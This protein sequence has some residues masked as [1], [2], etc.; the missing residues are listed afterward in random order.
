VSELR[1][2]NRGDVV[3][4]SSERLN[5]EPFFISSRDFEPAY[6]ALHRS[7]ELRRRVEAGRERLSHCL[8]CPRNC[9]VNRLVDKTAACKTGRYARVA[10]Y[11]PHSG[12]EN[13]LRG[14]RGSGT[15]FFAWCN[16][17][18]VFCQN[19]DISQMSAGVECS[20]SEIASMMLE[21][22]DEGCHNINFV[23]PE[24]VVPQLL[25]A[26]WIAAEAGLRLPIV[27]NTSAYDSLDSLHLLD[28]V[29]D[30][31]M[32]DFKFWDSSLALRYLKAKD[33]PEVARR[34]I[35]EMHR[36]VG[37]LKCDERGLAKRGVLVRHLLMPG[38]IDDTKAIL[39]F[40]AEEVSIDT[41]V[42][43]MSQYHPAGKV[44]A[45]KYAELDRRPTTEE[46]RQAVEAAQEFGL[47]RLDNR[48]PMR[49]AAL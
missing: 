37:A 11:F 25:E 42:N 16:L 5:L 46:Y 17:R 10:S 21:L 39:R 43:I 1:D 29:I 47:W 49:S 9:G 22:Q 13:C 45:E 12:E 19:S 40:L 35:Q 36:Q 3:V 26:L 41:Y 15:I 38:F 44:S 32:P 48:H 18:C 33:Y 24:H 20:P 23:T 4:M 6:R 31:Y 34:V 2:A 14:W 7:G 28:G 8:V 27:Y 30:I